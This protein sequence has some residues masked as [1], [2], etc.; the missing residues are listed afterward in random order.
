M[1]SKVQLR[2]SWIKLYKQLNHAG[3]V[4]EHYGISRFTLR[5]WY[6]RYNLLGEEGLYDLSSIPKNFPLQKRNEIDENLIID[7]RK[8]RNLGV[9]RIQSELKRLHNISFST[10]TIHKVL[11]KYAVAP[12]RLKRHYRKQVKRYSCKVPGERVQMD[13]CKIANGLYQ[14][15]AIDDCTRYKALALYTRRTATNTLDFLDQVLIRIPFPIQQIQTDRGQEF[16]AYVVQEY[17]KEHKIKFRPIKPLSPYLNGKV[18]RTQKT[19][20]DE[21][22]SSVDPKDQELRSKLIAWEEYYNK[23]RAHGSLHGKTP[24][25]KYKSLENTIPSIKEIQD[26]YDASKEPFAIQNYKHDQLFKVLAKQK[27]N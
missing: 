12:L 17:L 5:K 14:Y 4:C 11:K 21:F 6:K 7:L 23:Q 1:D 25:E 22:Y 18:E 15:T 19:D 20:L 24:W 13:V 10:A 2:L 27:V 16:F 3:K 26:N 8:E 9:R